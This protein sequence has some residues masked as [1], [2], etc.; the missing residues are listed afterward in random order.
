MEKIFI[1][2]ERL[3]EFQRNFQKKMRLMIIL[4]S[5]KKAVL[6]PFFRRWIFL[7][8]PEE[9]KLLFKG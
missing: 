6:H 5:H 2:S 7:E 1:Y 3:E 4:K 8:K 9:V